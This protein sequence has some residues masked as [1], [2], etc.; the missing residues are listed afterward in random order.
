MK[1]EL[2]GIGASYQ[3]KLNPVGTEITGEWQQ[4]GTLPLIFKRSGNN[5]AGQKTF[6]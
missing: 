5:G 2:K 1:L 3:G 4:G 6:Q